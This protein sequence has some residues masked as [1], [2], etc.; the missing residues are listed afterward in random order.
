MT[1]YPT[2]VFPPVC[3]AAALFLACA[4]GGAPAPPPPSASTVTSDEMAREPVMS[5]EQ[6]LAGR[7]AGVTVS[8][9]PGGGIRVRIGGPTSFMSGQEPLYMVDG[10]PVQAG[11]NGTLSW[12]NPHDI[13][14]IEVLK[15]ASAAIYGVR[16]ANGVIVIK[17]KGSH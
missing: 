8:R 2:R 15:G 5:L 13:E 9:A 17:T 6:L 4:K 10:A 1:W 12:L 11:P 3:I 14:S 7:V 16:G